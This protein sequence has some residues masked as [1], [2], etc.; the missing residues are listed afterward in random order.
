MVKIINN[1]FKWETLFQLISNFNIITKFT[2]APTQ[3]RR[4]AAS[5]I[6]SFKYTYLHKIQNFS[7]EPEKLTNN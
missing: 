1:S 4:S 2:T 3:I 7:N 6:F 5:K